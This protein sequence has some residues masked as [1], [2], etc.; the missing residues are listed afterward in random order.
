[1]GGSGRSDDVAGRRWSC[2][3][4]PP[5]GRQKWGNVPPSLF[6]FHRL[7]ARSAKILPHPHDPPITPLSPLLSSPQHCLAMD[8]GG[9]LFAWGDNSHGQCGQR[10]H[11][12][13][14]NG[15]A[16]VEV[17]THAAAIWQRG[18]SV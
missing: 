9:R 18:R 16:G 10:R 1:M 14:A 17:Q 12:Q 5:L 3:M 13:V 6:P 11:M 15:A 7:M 8:D 4:P 2:G